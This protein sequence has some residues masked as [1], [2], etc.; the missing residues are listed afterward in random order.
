[1][2]KSKRPD[3]V[4]I[5]L[6]VH[7]RQLLGV[8]AKIRRAHTSQ[9]VRVLRP[10]LCALFFNGNLMQGAMESDDVLIAAEAN[11]RDVPGPARAITL[12]AS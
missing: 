12:T 7:D 2:W 4:L 5:A 9:P 8:V 6:D 10:R 3:L 1:M 11:D